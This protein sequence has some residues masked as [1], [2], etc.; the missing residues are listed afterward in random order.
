MTAVL[1]D[2]METITS[3]TDLRTKVMDTQQDERSS[4]VDS[5]RVGQL[6]D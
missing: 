6:G 1:R 4:R 5:R 2:Q 3:K